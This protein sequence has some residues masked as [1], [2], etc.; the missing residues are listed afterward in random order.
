[1]GKFVFETTPERS[2]LMSKIKAKDTKPEILF[3]KALWAAGLRYRKNVASLPGKPD[4]V[5]RKY[6]IAVF[7]D[8][9]FWHGYNWG[10]KKTTIKSNR[11]FW[12]P[13][14]ERNML[15]DADANASLQSLGYTVIRFWDH[16]VLKGLGSCVN[17][18]LDA[19]SAA[20][21]K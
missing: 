10:V 3:R 7:I 1:M 21:A 14:I 8:G 9:A 18:V 16:E 19:V 2:K 17:K 13:K 4:V 11:D 5:M 6:K 20:V 12:I 15:R